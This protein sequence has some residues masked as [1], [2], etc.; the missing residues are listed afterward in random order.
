M[1]NYLIFI[2]LFFSMTM[3][4]QE[5][6]SIKEVDNYAEIEGV[7]SNRL[8]LGVKQISEEIISDKY[9]ICENGTPISVIIESIE[10]PTNSV[11]LGPFS[12]VRK[13][14]IVKVKLLVNGIEYDGIGESNTDV[15]TTFI[16]LQD[17]NLPFEKSSFSNALKK[18]LLDVISKL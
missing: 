18:S 2:T 1:R 17:E 13:K 4:S 7:D 15:K 14:T 8:K 12:K 9:E 16:E 5:C 10:A 11:S 3:F 6:Y